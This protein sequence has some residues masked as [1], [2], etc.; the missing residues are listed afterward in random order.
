MLYIQICRSAGSS[1]KLWG[2][3]ITVA[4]HICIAKT[5]FLWTI[6]EKCGGICPHCPPH[7]GTYEFWAIPPLYD[8]AEVRITSRFI[9]EIGPS[10]HLYASVSGVAPIDPCVLELYTTHISETPV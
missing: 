7:S 3:K 10:R 2:Q 8:V 4:S 6:H 1:S 5:N 9:N